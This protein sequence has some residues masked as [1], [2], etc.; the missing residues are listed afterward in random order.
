MSINKN[1]RTA[2]GVDAGYWRIARR[3][4]D[5]INKT[6]LVWIYGYTSREAMLAGSRHMDQ[7][8]LDNL[9]Y[10]DLRGLTMRQTAEYIIA[11]APEFTAGTPE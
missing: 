4:F 7:I 10:A 11:N 6:V 8:R 9:P 5:D 3:E 2:F 1:I